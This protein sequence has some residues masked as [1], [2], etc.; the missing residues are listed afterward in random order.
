MLDLDF[1]LSVSK[2]VFF[3]SLVLIVLN[4]LNCASK[5]PEKQAKIF[6]Y[7]YKGETVKPVSMLKGKYN[8][9]LYSP[10]KE[11]SENNINSK[12]KYFTGLTEIL[13][14]WTYQG[15]FELVTETK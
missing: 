1:G 4:G 5:I 8:F 6:L 12:L 10:F 3:I 2:Q 11:V 15:E 13:F 7:L 14:H 9:V